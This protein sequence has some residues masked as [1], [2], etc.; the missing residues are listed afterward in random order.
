M[1][2]GSATHGESTLDRQWIILNGGR[3]EQRISI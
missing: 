1:R 2:N 3:N